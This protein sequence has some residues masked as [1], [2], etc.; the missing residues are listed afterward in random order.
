MEQS[1]IHWAK[2]VRRRKRVRPHRRFMDV[3]GNDLTVN[4]NDIQ[5]FGVTEEDTGIG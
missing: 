4:G 1:W 5:R 2:D 3:V